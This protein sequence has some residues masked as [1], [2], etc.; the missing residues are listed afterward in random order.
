MKLGQLATSMQKLPQAPITSLGETLPTPSLQDLG[1]FKNMFFFLY[2]PL[3][4]ASKGSLNACH[5][6]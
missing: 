6:Q 5:G 1:N 3:E 4:H 2:L